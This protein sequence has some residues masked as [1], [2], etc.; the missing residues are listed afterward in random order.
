ML[1]H[2]YTCQ[3]P[4]CGAYHS[5]IHGHRRADG[6]LSIKCPECG[7]IEEIRRYRG[8]LGKVTSP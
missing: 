1:F 8:T 4:D 7:A 3:D 2:G 6:I 5:T